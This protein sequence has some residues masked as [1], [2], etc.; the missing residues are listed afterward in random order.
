[1]LVLGL[2]G[3]AESVGVYQAA[4]KTATLVTFVLYAVNTVAAPRF[5]TLYAQ[6]RTGELAALVRQAAH[7]IFWPTLGVVA[8]LVAA[9]RPVLRLF[10]PAFDAAY[11]PLV[12]LVL[13][14]LVNAGVGSVAYLL[15]MTGR[16]RHTM[17]VVGCCAVANV[18]L[19]AVLIPRLGLLGAALA[20]GLSIV[21][22]N[23]WLHRIVV[24]E[25][26]FSPS[27]LAALRG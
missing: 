18:A 6:G 20:S 22:W 13:A 9:G 10:G 23:L 16:Q 15:N 5:A 2:I 27:I 4:A 12:L 1:M 14:Q 17:W 7:A 21:A 8:F 11:A 24:R 25:L 26:G 19:N 3:D